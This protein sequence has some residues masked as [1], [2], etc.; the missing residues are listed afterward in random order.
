M[1]FK[2]LVF[3]VFQNNDL[4]FVSDLKNSHVFKELGKNKI[5]KQA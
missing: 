1:H 4:N 5:N 3:H 2:T